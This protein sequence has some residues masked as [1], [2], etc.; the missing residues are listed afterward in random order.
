MMVLMADTV[1]IPIYSV[2]A[3]EPITFTMWAEPIRLN[4]KRGLRKKI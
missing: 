4:L 1:M 2:E 3:M